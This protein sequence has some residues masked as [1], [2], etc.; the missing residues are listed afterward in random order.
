MF[1]A[2]EDRARQLAGRQRWKRISSSGSSSSYR[3]ASSSSQLSQLSHRK[4]FS[5]F[6]LN[7]QRPTRIP[8][9]TSPTRSASVDSLH[10]FG[11]LQY[12]VQPIA[13]PE[14]EEAFSRM[15]SKNLHPQ[16]LH[17]RSQTEYLSQVLYDE[18]AP[19]HALPP[20][21]RSS[22]VSSQT[23]QYGVLGWGAKI[24]QQVRH[25]TEPASPLQMEG[26]LST[27][28]TAQGPNGRSISSDNI[29]TQPMPS[30]RGGEDSEPRIP[31]TMVQQH[32]LWD[33]L[34]NTGAT[35]RS[36]MFWLRRHWPD[37][38][39]LFVPL[40][41]GSYGP[42]AYPARQHLL[43]TLGTEARRT[44]RSILE[45]RAKAILGSALSGGTQSP[46][47][48]Q[49]IFAESLQDAGYP[50]IKPRHLFIAFVNNS[51]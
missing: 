6:E 3:S 4:T 1:G 32:Q 33:C 2:S 26:H 7:P 25:V 29:S 49:Q 19:K 24:L 44:I 45:E 11:R 8:E 34:F 23:K 31:W 15:V 30:M 9:H 17:Q 5:I 50:A 16:T 18:T 46:I 21:T 37:K 13:S 35:Y 39:A 12:L 42:E 48:L 28:V 20:P 27:V 41:D 43:L 14:V 10:D 38:Y 51:K 36:F 40:F 47:E 22:A